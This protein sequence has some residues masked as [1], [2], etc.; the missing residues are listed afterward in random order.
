VIVQDTATDIFSRVIEQAAESRLKKAL[1]IGEATNRRLLYVEEAAPH[2]SLTE[3]ELYNMISN[4]QLCSVKHGRERWS[5]S[6][7]YGTQGSGSRRVY[8]F[9]D[10]VAFRVDLKL[11]RAGILGKT[12]IQIL[13]SLRELGFDSPAELTIDIKQGREV[14]VTQHAGESFSP[15]GITGNCSSTSLAISGQQR[16]ELRELVWMK[17][18]ETVK[19]CTLAEKEGRSAVASTDPRSQGLKRER[20]MD[21]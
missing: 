14:V 12:M 19:A 1:N 3:R 16:A 7:I 8:N 11:R 4:H 21:L 5:I 15:L 10:L 13:E 18:P 6:G 2:L 20:S 17:E 9:E